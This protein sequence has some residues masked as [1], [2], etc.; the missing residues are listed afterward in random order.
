MKNRLKLAAIALGLPW[1]IVGAIQLLGLGIKAP[2]AHEVSQQAEVGP[3]FHVEMPGAG[4]M[5]EVTIPGWQCVITGAGV[6]I[7]MSC[8]RLEDIE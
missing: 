3:V 6:S 8:A 4:A 2:V 1:A 5:R 7:A